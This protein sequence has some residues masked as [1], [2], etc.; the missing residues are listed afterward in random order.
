MDSYNLDC[1]VV[2]CKSD[3]LKSLLTIKNKHVFTAWFD[4]CKTATSH[5]AEN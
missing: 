1:L 4:I 5:S 3:E 2:A